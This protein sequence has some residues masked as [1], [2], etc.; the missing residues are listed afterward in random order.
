MDVNQISEKRFYRALQ[1]F[2]QGG[3]LLVLK[4]GEVVEFCTVIKPI[5]SNASY[6]WKIC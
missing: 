4:E 6:Y 5:F 3:K 1:G 2:V